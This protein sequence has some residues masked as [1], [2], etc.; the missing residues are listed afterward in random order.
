M[1]SN[2]S[3]RS[4]AS[5]QLSMC[6]Y[7]SYLSTLYFHF[8][9]CT[10]TDIISIWQG[11]FEQEKMKIHIQHYKQQQAQAKHAM[12]VYDYDGWYPNLTE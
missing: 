10:K 12:S 5:C 1:K 7:K 11:H 8:L 3:I 2:A 4:Q 9:S 6:P